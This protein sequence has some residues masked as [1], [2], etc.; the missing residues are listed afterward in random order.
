MT[1]TDTAC[2]IS[3]ATVDPGKVELTVTNKGKDVTEVYVYAAGDRP[4][5]EVEHIQPG[6]KGTFTVDIGGGDYQVACKPGEKGDGIRSALHVTGAAASTASD[7]SGTQDR[8][9][10]RGVPSFNT[11]V[12]ASDDQLGIDKT[13]T[14]VKGQSVNFNL[15]NSSASSPHGLQVFGPDGVLL[16]E[17]PSTPPN[18]A[19]QVALT[20]ST[21]GTYR[22]VDPLGDPQNTAFQGTF[23]V[24][25]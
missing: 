10:Y 15:H 17:I 4:L 23:E 20:F 19:G 25:E 8:A 22:Y 7:D 21:P 9:T 5:G 11:D 3:R 14:V 13:L 1:S 24:I 18:G 6:A 2:D 16:G 12:D